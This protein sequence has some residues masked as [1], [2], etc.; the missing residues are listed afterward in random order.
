MNHLQTEFL[1]SVLQITAYDCLM[2]LKQLHRPG[3][4]SVKHNQLTAGDV[5]VCVG[6]VILRTFIPEQE[7]KLAISIRSIMKKKSR[8]NKTYTDE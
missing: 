5:L 3:L 1:L 2:N 7:M 6:L 8:K 4:L